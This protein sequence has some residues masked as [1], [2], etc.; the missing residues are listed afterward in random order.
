MILIPYLK[1]FLMQAKVTKSL[2]DVCWVHLS[3]CSATSTVNINYIRPVF[4]S[5]KIPAGVTKQKDEINTGMNILK[6]VVA[7]LKL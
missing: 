5:Y 1:N 6:D 7:V 2:I 3:L 4:S